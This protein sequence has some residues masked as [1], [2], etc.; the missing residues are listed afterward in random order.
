MFCKHIPFCIVPYFLDELSLPS[1]VIPH[2]LG[3]CNFPEAKQSR[4]TDWRKKHSSKELQHCFLALPLGSVLVFHQLVPG[5][6][7]V[8]VH[9]RGTIHACTQRLKNQH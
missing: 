2:S 4:L 9:I 5:P 1:F 6:I 3:K 8:K 7:K